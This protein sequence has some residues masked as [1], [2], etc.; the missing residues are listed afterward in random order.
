MNIDDCDTSKDFY[1]NNEWMTLVSD[2]FDSIIA[3]KDTF[4]YITMCDYV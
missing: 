2:F 1:V 3:F 4:L